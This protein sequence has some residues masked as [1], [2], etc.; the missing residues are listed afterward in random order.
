MITEEETRKKLRSFYNAN[1]FIKAPVVVVACAVPKEAW[2]R[3]DGEE[4]W[5][6]DV[7][8]AMQSLILV[9]TESGLGTCWIANFNEEKARKVL[10]V[11]KDWEVVA[12]T[13]LGYA[14]EE[15]GPARNRKA[16]ED[17][18]RFNASM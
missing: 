18:V 17:I 6:V 14:D 7:A 9:A 13:P 11:P 5:K 2:Q 8:I 12:L 4:Y 10:N 1:W 3:I 16:I 15:R